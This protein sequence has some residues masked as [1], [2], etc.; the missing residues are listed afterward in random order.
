MKHVAFGKFVDLYVDMSEPIILDAYVQWIWQ[1]TGRKI[2]NYALI[3]RLDATYISSDYSVDTTRNST[4]LQAMSTDNP[5]YG[6]LRLLR[7]TLDRVSTRDFP[8][9]HMLWTA[10]H[11]ELAEQMDPIF[12][13]EIGTA[14]RDLVIISTDAYKNVLTCALVWQGKKFDP[15]SNQGGTL[16][17]LYRSS[18]WDACRLRLT[19]LEEHQDPENSERARI[20]SHWMADFRRM[21]F[22]V[23]LSLIPTPQ[24]RELRVEP[25]IKDLSVFL[26]EIEKR[27]HQFGYLLSNY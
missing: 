16:F 21:D 1:S 24:T 7:K 6:N 3:A 23:I 26:P 25:G 5:L 11:L 14:S 15:Q 8:N 20:L 13:H 2:D 22:L 18:F 27:I 19:D 4:A 17:G 9:S 12:R 10:W